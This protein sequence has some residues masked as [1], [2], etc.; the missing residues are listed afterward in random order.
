[1]RPECLE[2]ST[3]N[4][5]ELVQFHN[6]KLWLVDITDPILRIF[7][8]LPL[9]DNSCSKAMDLII[10]NNKTM[11]DNILVM[12]AY[13]HIMNE[14][15]KEYKETL[16]KINMF[17]NQMEINS[18]NTSISDNDRRELRAYYQDQLN[19]LHLKRKVL[20]KDAGVRKELQM[21]Y[22]NAF[23]MPNEKIS[24]Q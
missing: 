20:L 23:V 24:K 7:D 15:V 13:Q 1:M 11:A 19:S 5:L 4:C 8:L 16:K 21:E 6:P 10:K 22:D 12:A 2:F 9:C 18:R 14:K 17:S 3:R